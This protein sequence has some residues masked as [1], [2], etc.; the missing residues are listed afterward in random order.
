[1]FSVLRIFLFVFLAGIANIVVAQE[2]SLGVRS[3][4]LR[5]T[6]VTAQPVRLAAVSVDAKVVGQLARTT[7][8]LTFRN[9]N[10][11]VLEGEL[12]FPLLDGQQITGFALDIDGKWRPAVPVE[13]ARGQ[14]VFE[15]VTRTR[16]DPALLE[17]T[18][19]NSFKLRL[20]PIPTLGERKV[21]LTITER[22]PAEASGDVLYRLP[23][24]VAD[25]L[26]TFDFRLYAPGLADGRARLLRGLAGADWW[27]RQGEAKLEFSR[28]DY[29]P[30][31]KVEIALSQPA[32]PL[33]LTEE[34]DGRQYFY[35]EIPG[36]DL[37]QARRPAPRRLALVWDA[38]G[39]GAGR[40]HGR[41]FRLLDAWFKS[42]GSTEVILTLARDRA[43]H[44]GRFSI[45]HGDWSALRSVLD[46]LAYDGATNPAAFAPS[47]PADA[48]LLF[49]DGLVN[50]GL[51]KMPEFKLPL[52]AVSAA[53]SAD[54]VRLRHA[55]EESG[56]AFVDLMHS[57]P[58]QGARIL[59]QLPAR[60][61][62]LRSNQARDLV[63][64]PR[65]PVTGRIAVA[66]ILS[67]AQA[68]IEVEWRTP[69]G[70]GERQ[71]FKVVQSRDGGEF[72]S[73]EWARL[74]VAQLEPEFET[75]R[76]EIQRIGK[77]FALVTRGTS[78]IVLDRLQDYVRYEIQ[79]PAEMR[80]DYDRMRGQARLTADR[81]A[82]N[83]LGHVI[84]RFEERKRW[85]EQDF[86]KGDKPKPKEEV[87][88]MEGAA[89][90]EAGGVAV[91][92][93]GRVD[94]APSA[95]AAAPAPAQA[96]S[97]AAAPASIQMAP[98]GA[99]A[100]MA[101]ADVSR[102]VTPAEP[103]VASIRL[104]RW[105]AD[106]VYADRLRKADA[107]DLYR[108]YLDERPNY[109]DSTA[110]F[111]DAADVVFDRG[112]ADLALRILSNL[113]EMDLENRHILRILGYRLLQARQPSLAVPI[114]A[115]V[116]ELA[117][118]EPQS[119]RDLGLALADTGQYQ[120]AVDRLYEVVRRPWAGNF[121]DIELVTLAELNAIV[122]TAPVPVDTTAMEPSLV[123]NLPLD[124]RAVLTWDANDT[125]IDLWVTDPNG[126]KASY[127]NRLTYQGGAM[128]R[129]VTRG[130]GPE[131]F[132]LKLA[133]PGKYLVQA[134][135]Y[136][137]QQQVVSRST[138][139]QLRLST[140][141][142][143]KRQKDQAVTLRLTGTKDVV[144]VGEFVIGDNSSPAPG[145]LGRN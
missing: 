110:F 73:Q 57:S 38:S 41:E 145:S 30:E 92:A 37:G 69:A 28:Q 3:P 130:Y 104:K 97:S 23:L 75:H 79:P 64:S 81:D 125:D 54:T 117:P 83:H 8:Q 113:A 11:R 7:V 90:Q 121:P 35:A 132:S 39:S 91:Y 51:P 86:P 22:L 59:N 71:R 80:A 134:Q 140:G 127:A 4:L 44:G 1:M 131:E 49:S 89:G 77:D 120:N 129:D 68:E 45:R 36:K 87:L 111:L 6:D 93:A 107:K 62:A 118:N 40:D 63:A 126:D 105:S 103:P 21:S 34:R 114:F 53:A 19:G 26:D 33:V 137:H 109:T 24:P 141:F 101:P 112:Q 123:R 42:V 139:L 76:G 31:P 78:L 128:S 98:L 9:P 65:D 88:K 72:A 106:A 12:Q 61:I 144:T 56:G 58:E 99:S 5:L 135:F 74:K 66:G 43:E 2:P 48:V 124:L 47:E 15:E 25:K 85:W 142:G 70:H 84:A 133:K 27:H 60:L 138:T 50:Y 20:Y 17:A 96:R 136:G 102:S 29:R 14:E 100:A 52:L 18:Q 95:P 10:S 16:I 108:V 122:A 32:K 55:A 143:S 13:K 67:E 46:R 82:A 116:L 119:W 115:R 94:N